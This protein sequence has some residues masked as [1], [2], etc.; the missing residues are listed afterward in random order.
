MLGD[1]AL[2]QPHRFE[3]HDRAPGQKLYI[4]GPIRDATIAPRFQDKS[5]RPRARGSVLGVNVGF[6]R[7]DNPHS[8]CFFLTEP[9]MRRWSEQPYFMDRAADFWG[10]LES[11]ATLGVMRT[12]E[13]YK[14]SLENA[15]FLEVHHLDHR[16]LGRYVRPMPAPAGRE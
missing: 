11:A 12:F 5:V 8:G 4:D 6:E 13:V 2:L 9:Q 1:R 10:P 14:P 16:Y 15:G 7:V 3:T